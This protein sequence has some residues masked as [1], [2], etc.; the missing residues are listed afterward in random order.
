VG[1]CFAP[2]FTFRSANTPNTRIPA[3][4]MLST[5]ERPELTRRAETMFRIFRVPDSEKRM[6]R[7]N[8]KGIYLLTLNT[9]LVIGRFRVIPS[10]GWLIKGEMTDVAPEAERARLAK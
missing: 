8:G 1:A 9:L 3:I 2:L 10:I 7:P 6:R 5:V 4:T